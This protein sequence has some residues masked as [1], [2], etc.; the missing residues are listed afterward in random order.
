MQHP[1]ATAAARARTCVSRSACASISP[2]VPRPPPAVPTGRCQFLVDHRLARNARSRCVS[3][4]LASPRLASPHLASPHLA[5]PRLV[6]SRLVSSRLVSSRLVSSHLASPGLTS[7]HLASL[8]L[9]SSRLVSSRLVSFVVTV[10]VVIVAIL[11]R[12]PR[13]DTH[14]RFLEQPSDRRDVRFVRNRV[15]AVRRRVVVSCRVYTRVYICVCVDVYTRGLRGSVCALTRRD[16]C[17]Y[18]ARNA[19]CRL[20]LSA[21]RSNSSNSSSSRSSSRRSSRQRRAFSSL[22]R[23]PPRGRNPR[24]L[25]AI[26]ISATSRSARFLD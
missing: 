20:A 13:L 23:V 7:P 5:S 4:R 11:H 22:R 21:C 16:N 17:A 25:P 1:H 18:R 24:F 15:L 3:P 2:S 26:R 8:R 9:A 14:G 6:S 10:I 12:R 19:Q